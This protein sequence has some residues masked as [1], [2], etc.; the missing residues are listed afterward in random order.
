M[1]DN[2]KQNNNDELQRIKAQL[3]A[4]Q[5]Q[6]SE[7][8]KDLEREQNVI[9]SD[10]LKNKQKEQDLAKKE[11]F[12]NEKEIEAQN[13]F[14]KIKADKI[15]DI[16]KELNDYRVKIG[17]EIEKEINNKRAEMSQSLTREIEENKNHLSLRNQELKSEY[18]KLSGGIEEY[19]KKIE[20]LKND[21]EK[22][23]EKIYEYNQEL[24]QTM[25]KSKILENKE[26]G[27]EGEI[28]R[29]VKTLHNDLLREIDSLRNRKDE[30]VNEKSEIE[31]ELDK[32][33]GF[34]TK[35]HDKS[36]EE[37]NDII[38]GYKDRISELEEFKED[39]E[40]KYAD[41]SDEDLDDYVQWKEWRSERQ[42]VIN[43]INKLKK[44][45]MDLEIVQFEAVKYQEMV[46]ELK[47]DL[48]L[49]CSKVE[50]LQA[51]LLS[52]KEGIKADY[53]KIKTSIEK[54]YIT[55]DE[56]VHKE[57]K[58]KLYKREIENFK[59]IEWLERIK[60]GCEKSD[61]IYP[62]RLI[63]AFHTSLKSSQWT[64]LTLMA[65]TSGTGKSLLPLVYSYYGGI[66]FNNTP[67][68]P[69]WTD[70][71]DL[72]GYYDLTANDFNATSLLKLLSQSQRNSDTGEGFEDAMLLVLL[73]E[74]NLAQPEQY[75]S[76][77]LSKLEERRNG[78]EAILEIN[79]GTSEKYKLNLGNNI[80]FCG[81]MNEDESTHTISD[82][83]IDRSNVM[84]FPTPKKLHSRKNTGLGDK[85][86]LLKREDWKK[87]LKP[88]DEKL[89]RLKDDELKKKLTDK[90]NTQIDSFKKT[91]ENITEKLA[92]L[93][94]G[95]G[96]RVWQ[97]AEH[98]ISV[99]PE[100]LASKDESLLETAMNNAFEDQLAMKVMPKLRGVEA[101]E[102]QLKEI[103]KIISSYPIHKDFEKASKNHYGFNL[104]SADY[105]LDVDKSENNGE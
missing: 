90:Y 80:L 93:G 54:P 2:K 9:N 41:I 98:Y 29:R 103:G 88:Y 4:K 95:V 39:F 36:A 60:K 37:L 15:G 30:L 74:L 1:S 81:T 85:S 104:N 46:K 77:F 65:G 14:Q 26:Q 96:N 48:E 44:E 105:L 49:K 78:G 16:N 67:V 10:R 70:P 91:L 52:M 64:S 23:D 87:W 38:N 102:N 66:V 43:E 72:L 8:E 32:L 69:N 92:D 83:V 20:I 71:R 17:A 79:T 73:D 13:G 24:S 58:R 45:K 76:D 7:R 11:S 6:L 75:F 53:D 34:K 63:D 62:S 84:V 86:P 42:N 82:K 55:F 47:N 89:E 94:R 5:K 56:A 99:Y 97:A 59:E 31:R 18:N 51:D 12:L 33:R 68:Q 61:I 19:N 22:L 25:L 100:V 28:N 27:I 57:Y 101:S 40:D 21:R 3:T 35:Y 50:E